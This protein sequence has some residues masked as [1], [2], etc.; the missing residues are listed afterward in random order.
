[1]GL[2]VIR[3]KLH[4]NSVSVRATEGPH[5]KPRASPALVR[6]GKV[7]NSFIPLV[8]CKYLTSPSTV[9]CC[10]R[11]SVWNKKRLARLSS[12]PG[13]YLD[14]EKGATINLLSPVMLHDAGILQ[15]HYRVAQSSGSR[16][17]RTSLR[18][19]WACHPSCCTTQ[20]AQP[21]NFFFAG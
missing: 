1:M 14:R 16:D 15:Q 18:A 7:S 4:E 5:A 8:P 19:T 9:Q 2:N 21:A 20:L 6:I 3:K 12:M 11:Q 13:F 17:T 10:Q